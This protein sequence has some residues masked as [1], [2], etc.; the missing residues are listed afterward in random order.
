MKFI[1]KKVITQINK[2]IITEWNQTNPPIKEE[3]HVDD[4][5]LDEVLSL[6][7][8]NEDYITKASYIMAAMSWAQ[9][10]SGGNKRTGV[11]C[12][13]TWLRI[14]GYTLTT[15][16]D[17]EREYLRSLLFEIQESRKKMDDFTLAKI[18]LYVSRR[19]KKHG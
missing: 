1:P 14:N 4:T 19:L 7:N 2:G 16:N 8:E 11:V 13:E 18:I 17:E 6:V 15:E 10:F 3:F 12:A 5:R 9:P